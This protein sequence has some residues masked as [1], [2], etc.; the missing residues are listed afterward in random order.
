V[1][2]N[3]LQDYLLAHPEF[4]EKQIQYKFRSVEQINPISLMNHL[5]IKHNEAV[6]K[7]DLEIAYL[8]NESS[9]NASCTA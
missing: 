4:L 6:L 8:K 5:K 1:D 3:I 7:S 9:L 2:R